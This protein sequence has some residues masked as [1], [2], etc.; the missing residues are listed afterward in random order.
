MATVQ[1]NPKAERLGST[2]AAHHDE[3]Q[4]HHPVR[5]ALRGT[6]VFLDT[7]WRVVLLGPDGVEAGKRV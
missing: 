1:M 6:V 5:T 4:N 2:K 7:A 3:R